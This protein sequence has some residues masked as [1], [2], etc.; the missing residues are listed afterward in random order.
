ML[1]KLKKLQQQK[2][3]EGFTIIEVMIVLAIAGLIILIVLLAVPALQRNGRNTAIKND[4]SA[5]ASS[6]TTF[7]ADNDGK[8]PAVADFAQV[9]S[10]LTVGAATTSQSEAK[11]QGGT[12]VTTPAVA[13]TPA[14][15]ITPGT[16]VIVKGRDCSDK[17]SGRAFAIWYSI[18]TSKA[19][20]AAA[21]FNNKCIDT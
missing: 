3:S 12:T 2:S 18:E 11:V 7:A 19:V 1:N 6:I 4:A 9:G 17:A 13:V 16:I 14:T 10:T 20:P 5:V 8:T 21:P 15:A